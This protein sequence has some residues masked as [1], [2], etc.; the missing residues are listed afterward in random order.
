MKAL[1]KKDASDIFTSQ[2]LRDVEKKSGTE[3]GIIP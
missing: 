2:S 3:L 1:C